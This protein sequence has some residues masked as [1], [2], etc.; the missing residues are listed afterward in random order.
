M[1]NVTIFNEFIHEKENESVKAIYPDGIHMTLKCAL[2]GQDISVKTVTLD[3]ENCGLD[4]ET[5]KNTDVLIWW[6]HKGHKL[7]PDEVAERVR[8]EVHRGM[9]AIFLHSGHHSKPFKLLMG[10][11]CHLNWRE[12]GDYELIWVCNAAHPIAKGID[13][14]IQLDHEETYGEPFLIPEP[15]ELVFISSY[16]GGEV[17]R[18][19]CCYQRVNGR[20][21]Y[22]QPGHETYPTYKHPDIIKVIK[23]A[24]YWAKPIYRTE[25]VKGPHVA[26]LQIERSEG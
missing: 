19:G 25:E 15:D 3:D 2:E 7:V 6:G 21:F 1:I 26:K 17:F 12:N 5:L 20:I 4:E 24:I 23:N 11:P 18:A 22:F 13:R 16:E 14:Y 9:G 10:T 8:D